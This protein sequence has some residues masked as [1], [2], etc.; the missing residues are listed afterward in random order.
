MA[1]F[2]STQGLNLTQPELDFVDVDVD[3]DNRLYLDPYAIQ[4]R[5]DEWSAACGDHIRSFFNEVLDALRQG[6]DSR[7]AHLLGHLHEP[8]ETFL[9][10]SRGRPRGRGVGDDKA[11]HLAAALRRSTAFTTGVL[12]DISEAELFIPN[13]GPD[14]ISDLTTNIL[15]GLLA[16]YTVSQCELY[17]ISTHRFGSLGPT[18]SIANSD[19]RSQ[20]L[21]LPVCYQR[22]VL[23]VPKHSVRRSISLNSQ[24]FYNHHMASLLQT[25]RYI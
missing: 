7:A 18:W 10:Q 25:K 21:Q 6:N 16:E 15:R 24:E 14:T 11:R 12:S 2:A 22:P 20:M 19:W 4:I 3:T 1:R 17:N 5:D 23:L 13:V 9:G 8:N